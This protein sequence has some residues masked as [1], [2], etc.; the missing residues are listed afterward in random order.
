M[1]YIDLSDLALV[2]GGTQGQ[3]QAQ[4]DQAAG[5]QPPAGG[6]F[7]QGLQGFLGFLQSPGFQQLISGLQGLIG[8]FAQGGAPQGAQPAPTQAGATQQPAQ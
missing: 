6:G 7:L 3:P 8:Q 2:R 4:P 5:G 1:Q